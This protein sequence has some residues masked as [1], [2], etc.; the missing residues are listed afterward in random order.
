MPASCCAFTSNAT[1]RP[2][3][4]YTASRYLHRLRQAVAE[5]G[6]FGEGVGE[7]LVEAEDKGPRVRVGIASGTTLPGAVKRICI[8][9]SHFAHILSLATVTRIQVMLCTS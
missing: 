1:S 6:G 4:S 3:R 7:V 2:S 9:R 8:K 5:G